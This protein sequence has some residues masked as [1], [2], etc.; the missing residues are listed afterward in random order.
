[1]QDT[2]GAMGGDD[3]IDEDEWQREL[4]LALANSSEG[5]QNGEAAQFSSSAFTSGPDAASDDGVGSED[6]GKAVIFRWRLCT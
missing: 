4:D 5:G 6:A 3:D 1:M 2:A